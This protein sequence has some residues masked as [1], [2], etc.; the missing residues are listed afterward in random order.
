LLSKLSATVNLHS[1]T[2]PPAAQPWLPAIRNLKYRLRGTWF[3]DD[4]SL[5]IAVEAWHGL[6]VKAENFIFKA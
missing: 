3:I 6:R 4:E 5:K 1:S 2:T